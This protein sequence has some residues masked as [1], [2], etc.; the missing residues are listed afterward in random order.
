M[1]RAMADDAPIHGADLRMM[2]LDAVQT[3]IESIVQIKRILR[4]WR[5][6]WPVEFDEADV[7][8]EIRAL[9]REGL[10]DPYDIPVG[11]DVLEFVEDPSLTDDDIRRYWYLPTP[12]GNAQLERWHPPDPPNPTNRRLFH[13]PREPRDEPYAQLLRYGT[14][15]CS[16]ML[17]V[18]RD[19]ESLERSGHELLSRLEGWALER[20]R[21]PE[22]PGTFLPEGDTAVLH[23]FR[24]GREVAELLLAHS[25][26]LYDWIEPTL[27]EGPCLLRDDGSGWL[28]SIPPERHA[29][30]QITPDEYRAFVAEIPGLS[31][32]GVLD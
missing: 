31:I 8:A 2:I 15:Q 21:A 27:P 6:V 26:A 30:L 16:R 18:V 11:G 22:W 24:Y 9:V 19:P 14:T 12:A 28:V 1:C 13:F 25:R 29:Y 17:L 3:D 32:R 4:C 7:V 20:E 23:H 5:D 10:L